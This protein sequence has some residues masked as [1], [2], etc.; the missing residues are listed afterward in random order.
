MPMYW[1]VS[2][3]FD[4]AWLTVICLH[5]IM[6]HALPSSEGMLLLQTNAIYSGE[7]QHCSIFCFPR[8]RSGGITFV[9]TYTTLH[10]SYVLMNSSPSWSSSLI[11]MNRVFSFLRS[12]IR[13]HFYVVSTHIWWWPKAHQYS[14]SGCLEFVS[15]ATRKFSHC[16]TTIDSRRTDHLFLCE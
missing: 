10:L 5:M 2:L 13:P 7:L 15:Y 16:R 1:T 9:T 4:S 14:R 8:K 6:R 11:A 12:L 3:I